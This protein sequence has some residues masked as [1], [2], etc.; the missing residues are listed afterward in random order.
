MKNM[1]KNYFSFS[2]SLAMFLTG[3]IIL[4]LSTSSTV[5]AFETQLKLTELAKPTFSSVKMLKPRLQPSVPAAFKELP[6]IDNNVT[7]KP[8][9]AEK[10]RGY[11]LFARPITAPVYKHTKPIAWER[12]ENISSFA[13]PGEYEPL[14]FSLYPLRNIRNM[15]LKI[16]NLKFGKNIIS[17]ANLDLRALTYWNIRYP[18]YSSTNSYRALPELLEKVNTVNLQQHIC[19]RFWLKVKIPKNARPGIY[20][21]TV[22]LYENGAATAINLPIAMRVLDYKLKRDP[23]KHYS[24][25]YYSPKYQ[26]GS[27]RGKALS[28][29]QF[30]EFK[31]MQSYGID[32]FP[33]VGLEALPDGHGKLQLYLKDT[34]T[35]ELMIKAG[36]KGPIPLNGAIAAFYKKYVPS[37]TIGRHWHISKNPPNDKIYQAIEQAYRNLKQRAQAKGWPELI[38]CP[39]DEVASVS[40]EFSA[41]VYAAIRRAGIKTYITKNPS[42]ADAAVYRKYQSIDAWCSQPFAMPYDK[43]IADKKAQYWAYPNHNAGEMKNRVIAQKG[44]RMTYGYGL[45][46]SGYTTLI[47][48][49]WRWRGGG[50]VDPFDYLRSKRSGCGFRKAENQQLIPAV[51]WECF[52]EGYDDLRYLYTLQ[53]AIVKRQGTTDSQCQKLREKAQQLI[54]NIWNSIQP[55]QKYLNTNMWADETFQS[56]RW[57]IAILTKKLLKFPAVNNKIAPSVLVKSRPVAQSNNIASFIATNL[58]KGYIDSFN[59]AKDNYSKWQS[60][61]K[62]VTLKTIKGSAGKPLLRFTVNVDHKHD[63]SSENGTYPIGWPSIQYYFT[64]NSLDLTKYDY[65]YYRI[66]IDS[67]RS[68]VADDTTPLVMTFKC[69]AGIK[70]N[71]RIDLGGKQRSWLTQIISLKQLIARSGLSATKWHSLKKLQ[72]VIYERLYADGDKLQFDIAD[73]A[74]LK[75]NRPVIRAIECSN[76]I[77]LP[78]KHYVIN[79]S[80]F[81]FTKAMKN[82]TQLVITLTDSQNRVVIDKKMAVTSNPRAI[83]NLSS[84]PADDY[85][86]TLAIK[87]KN[88]RLLSS[89]T[90]KIKLI[91]GYL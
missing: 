22:T 2:K 1:K 31:T 12:I 91:K 47:P 89:K 44:G 45:W 77:M 4:M 36:F 23:N 35:V 66:K 84:L 38:C 10:K 69:Y 18:M 19:Q 15:R 81:G 32:M 72:L 53:D 83:L 50:K 24:V 57:E 16:S 14:T 39:L 11:I 30:N 65:L 5:S 86:L 7:L 37:G 8:T 29:A 80:G 51:Y 74:F 78:A 73:I 63:G 70:Y 3:Y 79:V 59:L 46:R 55:Q 34:P 62:E 75:F 26:F 48:W 67:N 33:V 9:L 25:Y 6:F 17:K 28:K 90:K 20:R 40:V 71:D 68:E 87:D 13:T 52:R 56:R 49:H 82:S 41:K 85:Q 42:A 27:L 64:Q 43:V 76:P 60:E 54:Q 58:Q 88:G 61:V 21:G